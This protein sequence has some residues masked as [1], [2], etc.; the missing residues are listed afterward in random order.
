MPDL[1]G[2]VFD[3]NADAKSGLGVDLFARNTET[4]SLRATTTD[5][6]GKWAISYSTEGRYDVRITLGGGQYFWIKYDDEVTVERLEAG[7]IFLRGTDDAFNL[8][9]RSTPTSSKVA[10]FPNNTGTVAELNLAQTFSA[11]QTFTGAVTVG[12]DGSGTDVIFYSGEAGDNF[13]WDASEEK[14][15]ITGTDGQTALD[16]ADGNLVVADS[17]TVSGNTTLNGNVTLGNAASDVITVNGT[18]A[19][20]NAVIFE[21][22]TADG[23]ETTLAVVDPTADHIIYMP[24]QDGFLGVFEV[25]STDQITSTPVELNILDG[26][27]VVV[28]EINAL[29][30]GSTAV[31]T[32]IAS[33]A[34]IL[35]S[36]KDYTGIRNLTITGDLTLSAGADGALR[37]TN[38]GENSIKIPDNQA[39]AL[40]IEEADNAYITFVTTNSSEAITVAKATTFSAGIA[41]A[42][43]IAAGTWNGTAIDGGYINDNIVSGQAEIT[44]GLATADEL[45]YSDGGTVKR[46]GVDTLTTY[47][48]GVNAGTVTSTGLSDSSGVI[49]LDIANMTASTGI[50][51]SDEVAVNDGGSLRK[52]TRANF[53]GSAAVDLGSNTLTTTGSLQ[54]R[55]IDYSDGDLAITIADSGLTTFAQ[56]AVF[57]G[58]VNVAATTGTTGSTSGALIVGGGVGIAENIETGGSA[59]EMANSGN[60]RI[61][62]ETTGGSG[63]ALLHALLPASGTGSAHVRFSQG[64][65]DGSANNMRYTLGYDGSENHFRLE[66]QDI[67]GSGTTGDIF[68]V[69]DGQTT[70]DADST[71]DDSV[72]DDYDD[73]M[74]LHRAFGRENRITVFEQGQEILKAN[75]D[76]LVEM[77]VLRKYDDGWIGHNDQR[78]EALLAGGIYQNRQRLDGA[79]SRLEDEIAELRKLIAV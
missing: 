28:G 7:E 11:N 43:T 49:S 25:V 67:N 13:T 5:E 54:V 33:K 30:L 38:A 55:T 70:I 18:V 20:A 58:D 62:A 71:W 9:F 66:S 3:I 61:T 74:V 60:V 45:L 77:G 72:Y 68:R 42:G 76:E 12:S 41:N 65:G 36:N 48:A 15:T 23:S 24:N 51:D 1:A 19:G 44:S 10:T 56:N 34:V 39:S 63:Q 17:L 79:I 4:T 27:S 46:V 53:I 35:D 50:A 8:E 40:I 22:A 6:D 26:A 73:A 32:A 78:M 31:G 64:G 57:S 37:F 47:L 59:I 21:G 2:F 52:M 69:D 14:L 29:D 16:I 75:T